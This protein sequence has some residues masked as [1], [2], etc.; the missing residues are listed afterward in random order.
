M[1]VAVSVIV[2]VYNTESYLNQCVESLIHQTLENVEF[3]FVDDGSTDGSVDILKQYQEKDS[4]IKILQQKNLYAGVA[5]NHGLEQATGKYII[6]LDSDD[7]FDP[8]MLRNTYRCAEKNQAE[9]VI[10]GFR[11][12]DDSLKQFKHASLFWGRQF[13]KGVFS[14]EDVGEQFFWKCPAFPWNKLFLKSFVDKHHLRFEAVR[15][16]NDAYFVCMAIAL[17][18]RM[19]FLDKNYVNYR[20][21]NQG[22]LQGASNLD[23]E[24]FVNC[25][26]SIKKGLTEAG[27]YHG[28]IRQ[29]AIGMAQGNVTLGMEPPFTQETLEA[30]YQYTKDHLIPDLFDTP[31]DFEQSFTV[32]NIYK[33]RD[34]SDFLCR[35]LQS[36]KEDKKNN[37]ISVSNP[38]VRIGRSLL[39]LPLK[40]LS[41]F[42]R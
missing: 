7:F 42:K 1:S 30:F 31:S 10:F 15:K 27:K 11:K 12:Y 5:R 38:A 2:P 29:S 41:V 19:V 18:E 24:S 39:A 35:Q 3:I 14:A 21:G 17:A 26:I 33:S 40:I 32:K 20:I 4:R 23:R 34:F 25:C 13:P 16:C 37:Y 28:A 22:S 36:E 6:F 9:I 8:D